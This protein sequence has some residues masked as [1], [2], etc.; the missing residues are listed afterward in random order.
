[1]E[2]VEIFM[3]EYCAQSLFQCISSRTSGRVRILLKQ[4]FQRVDRNNTLRSI[5]SL[6]IAE[7]INNEWSSGIKITITLTNPFCRIDAKPGGTKEVKS[8]D[9]HTHLLTKLLDCEI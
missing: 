7:H 8:C 5:N 2:A 9:D 4:R 3:V 1:M 6:N